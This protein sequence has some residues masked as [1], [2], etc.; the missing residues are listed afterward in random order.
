MYRWS[1]TWI[2]DKLVGIKNINAK[3]VSYALN[4]NYPNPFNPA[5][6]IRYSLAKPGN[7]SVRVY[8][9]LGRVVAT[10]VNEYQPIGTYEVNFNADMARYQLSSGVYFYTIDAGS[11]HAVKKMMLLK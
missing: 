3:P 8:D 5:T 9:I 7:V 10:L 1:Y 11:F 2:G 4:Q 6:I